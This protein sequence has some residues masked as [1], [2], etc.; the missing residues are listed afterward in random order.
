MYSPLSVRQPTG[1]KII[2]MAKGIGVQTDYG[3]GNNVMNIYN[4]TSQAISTIKNGNGPQFLEFSTYR[5]RTL[6]P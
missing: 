4:K 5:W 6:W 3:D 2:E 1:S